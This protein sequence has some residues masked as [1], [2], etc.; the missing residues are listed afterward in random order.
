MD[1]YVISKRLGHSD[2]STTR[3]VYS[4]LIDEYKM[5]SDNMIENV[6]NKLCA[7]VVH[8]ETTNVDKTAM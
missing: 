4:Y 5:R 8:K 3:R 6:L 7:Q 1:L 2:I